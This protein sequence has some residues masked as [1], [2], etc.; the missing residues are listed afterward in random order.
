[1][2]L[3]S[4]IEIQQNPPQKAQSRL[5]Q[6]ATSAPGSLSERKSDRIA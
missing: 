5:M 4:T 2:G 3:N 6:T 1:M